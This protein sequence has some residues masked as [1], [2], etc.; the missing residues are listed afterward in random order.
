[1]SG[2]SERKIARRLAKESVPKH[3]GHWTTTAIY[4]ILNN[5]KYAGNVLLQK[6]Y[7]TD[8][9]PFR[10]KMNH[11]ER[12]KYYV[13]NSHP[14]IISQDSFDRAQALIR[15]RN[16]TIIPGKYPFSLKI[17]CGHCG[18]TFKRRVTNDK[19]YWVCRNHDLAKDNCPVGRVPEPVL[20]QAF[21]RLHHKLCTHRR[22]ILS[23]MLE[24]LQAL[25]K[26]SA[27]GQ[28]RM[29]EIDNEI[30]SLGR[31]TMI[32][33]RLHG[34]GHMEAAHYYEQSQSINAQVNTLRRERRHL[35]EG[36]PE[37]VLID[38][39]AHLLELIK[40]NHQQQDSFDSELFSSMVQRITVTG[41][42]QARFVLINSLEVT[43][44][45]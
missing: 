45:L 31:Q 1:M 12:T 17:I 9:L 28:N 5:E 23:P 27:F 24:Q 18:S 44:T 22:D 41:S 4:P 32:L 20:E 42:G 16:T 40:E 15:Q 10:K 37:D 6:S 11:G 29:A 26:R 30:L 3:G 34:A 13:E 2:R 25:Q 14:A 8:G 36:N 39:T 33:H 21:L 19:A 35:L 38:Q 7:M 43:E